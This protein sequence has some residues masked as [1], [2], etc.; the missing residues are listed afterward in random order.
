MKMDD[1]KAATAAAE[2]AENALRDGLLAVGVPEKTLDQLRSRVLANGRSVVMVGSWPTEVAEKVAAALEMSA[3][4]M[5]IP[6][7]T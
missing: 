4:V 5:R 7:D 3:A 6:E 1:F 2:A